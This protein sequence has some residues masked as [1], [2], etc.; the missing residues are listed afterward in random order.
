[1]AGFAAE[2]PDAQFYLPTLA[3]FN[4]VD[5]SIF[6]PAIEQAERGGNVATVLKAASEQLNQAV[7]CK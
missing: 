6:S 7:G 3:N 5:S 1:V 2:S 4:Y